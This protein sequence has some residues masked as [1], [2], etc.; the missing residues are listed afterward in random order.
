V[1]ALRSAK[2]IYVTGKGGVGRSTVSAALGLA[3][4]GLGRRTI[5]CEVA[6]QDRLSRAFG[7]RPRAQDE[8]A[9]LADGLWGVSVDPQRA[10]R[11]W[12]GAQ[13]GSRTLSRLLFESNAFSYFAAAAPG[14]REIATLVKIWDLARA[15]RWQKGAA[16]YDLVIVDGPASGHGL[17]MLRTPR[18][19]SEIARMGPIH[20][21]TERVREMLSD[22]AH[23]AYVAVALAEEMPVNETLELERALPSIVGSGLARIVVNGL[24]PR[25][26]DDAELARA[27]AAARD[28]GGN[29]AV[30]R[31]V[32]AAQ[33]EAHWARGQREQLE[34]LEASARAPVTTLPFLFARELRGAELEKLAEQLAGA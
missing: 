22:P 19:F 1:E 33:A 28:G 2:L 21:Q 7:R 23:T 26:F 20:K 34:R 18:T 5:V 9:E 6:E 14:A 4:A 16:G 24:Y 25:R 13:L 15:D 30:R 12:L 8:E 29:G 17:G 3:A 10:L 27:N 32:A 11:E 31:A